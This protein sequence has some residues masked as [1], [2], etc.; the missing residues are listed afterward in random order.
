MQKAPAAIVMVMAGTITI[1]LTA[2]CLLFWIL[3][4]FNDRT[5]YLWIAL[6]ITLFLLIWA[7]FLY[8]LHSRM[9]LLQLLYEEAAQVVFQVPLL[10]L[11]AF[12]V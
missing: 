5:E 12:L 6:L 4:A 7:Y 1:L 2:Y 9:K 8:V 10:F 11:A 3:Y